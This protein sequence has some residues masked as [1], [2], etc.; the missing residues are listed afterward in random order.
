MIFNLI[1]SQA[2][3]DENVLVRMASSALLGIDKCIS[4]IDNAFSSLT[5]AY[6]LVFILHTAILLK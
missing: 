1:C 2:E 6:Q 4:D 3:Q 5:K